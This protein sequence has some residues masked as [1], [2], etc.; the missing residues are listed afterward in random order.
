MEKILFLVGPHASG[1]TYSTNLYLK[2][3]ENVDMI[4]TGPIMRSLHK[5]YAP[6][7]SMKEWVEFLENRYGKEIT[8]EIIAKE[9]GDRLFKS[10]AENH[11][12]IGFRSFEGI[13]YTIRRLKISN[14]SVLYLDCPRELLYE[15]YLARTHK[16]IDFVS[17]NALLDNEYELGLGSLRNLVDYEVI[18]YFYK[19]S[20]ED[21]ISEKMDDY[22]SKK[23]NIVLNTNYI[24]P[25]EPTYKLLEHDMYGI[26]PVHMI[27]NRPR[28]HAGFD[29]ITKTMTPVKCSMDGIVVS[30][31]LDE[32]IVSGSAKWNQRYGNKVEVLDASGKRLVY[33]H[34]REVLVDVGQEVKQNQI[35][36]LSGCS[37][38]SR[39]PHL[40]FEVRKHNTCHSGRENT[41]NPLEIMPERD[42]LA[43]NKHFDEEP[44]DKVWEMFLKTP[45]GLSD[46]NIPYAN[47]KKLIR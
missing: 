17:F 21:S 11:V 36:G 6:E 35:I 44:Y 33:A 9:I 26:R 37:G 22:F 20:N 29:I 34:L 40:H 43:L 25:V 14:Y 30:A 32:K 16:D 8:S 28:F 24:W 13:M 46:D 31:G 2:N 39:I 45:W 19:T 27:L 5:K 4:D 42:L 41:I 12:V 10:D 1:K 15:N 23:T 38:G 7:I 3:H 47:D 18:D